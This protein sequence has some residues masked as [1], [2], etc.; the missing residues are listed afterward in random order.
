M[1]SGTCIRK[2]HLG[3]DFAV[4]RREQIWFWLRINANGEG[5]TIGASANEAQ[6]VRDARL[7]IEEKLTES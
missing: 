4:W 6:A 7:L 2:H 5:G 3:L 1:S